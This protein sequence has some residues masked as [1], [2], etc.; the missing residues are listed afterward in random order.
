MAFLLFLLLMFSMAA[1]WLGDSLPVLP[2]QSSGSSHGPLIVGDVLLELL[3]SL[4]DLEV[5]LAFPEGFACTWLRA[6]PWG[7][8][9]CDMKVVGEGCT[10]EANMFCLWTGGANAFCLASGD[11]GG[12]GANVWEGCVFCC[13]CTSCPPLKL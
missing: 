11:D 6:F 5:A 12:T 4:L 9:A 8:V 3:L 1:S 7:S 10:A 2:V 13:C